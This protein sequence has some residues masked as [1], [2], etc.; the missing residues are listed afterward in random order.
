[1]AGE[2][3]HYKNWIRLQNCAAC[4]G[5]GPCEPHHA[6]SGTTY[7]PDEPP[8]AKSAGP[9]RGRGQRTHDKWLIP[10]HFS[11]HGEFTDHRGHFRGWTQE[12]RKR[13]EHEEVRRYRDMYRW[14]F[15]NGDPTVK[16]KRARSTL[17]AT[18][19]L[20]VAWRAGANAER[21]RIAEWLFE[22]A[23]RI[24]A[25]DAHQA[26]IDAHTLL[27]ERTEPMATP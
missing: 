7:D 13:W 20:S 17:C 16:P 3:P 8:P 9:K 22:T 5:P 11:C 10:L 25:P 23:A 2:L 1:M 6:Q 26:L 4:L 15:P 12:E 18:D 24:G 14:E 21:R 27:R 19:A